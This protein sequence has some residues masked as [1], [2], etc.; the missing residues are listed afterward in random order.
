MTE[1]TTTQVIKELKD[2]HQRAVH[3]KHSP[4]KPIPTRTAAAA[5]RVLRSIIYILFLV[6]GLTFGMTLH[7]SLEFSTTRG[8]LHRMLYEVT[9][10]QDITT[11]AYEIY[12][13]HIN[14]LLNGTPSDFPDLI[15]QW[16]VV[17]AKAADQHDYPPDL[18]TLKSLLANYVSNARRINE[19]FEKQGRDQAIKAYLSY[20]A[21][22]YSSGNALFIR[23]DVARRHII[24]TLVLQH[25]Q[26]MTQ[27]VTYMCVCIVSLAVLIILVLFL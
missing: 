10:T 12:S 6:I 1:K 24:E 21:D 18:E 16:N 2:S 17:I 9:S 8:A 11:Y 15:A 14:Y 26:A 13:S 7:S 5:G 25:E 22:A 19:V 27:A 23:L 4:P 20:R 3:K